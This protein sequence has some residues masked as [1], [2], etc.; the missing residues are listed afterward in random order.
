MLGCCRDIMRL[1]TP[2]D[3][4]HK[5]VRLKPFMEASLRKQCLA[6]ELLLSLIPVISPRSVRRSLSAVPLRPRGYSSTA[7]WH[8]SLRRSA[9]VVRTLRAG[10][11]VSSVRKGT[12]Q[13]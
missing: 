1:F 10:P 4:E 12:R 11:A 3:S 2:A 13:C 7:R 8:D 9:S 5:S 6:F